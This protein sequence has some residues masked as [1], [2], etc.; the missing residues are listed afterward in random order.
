METKYLLN[1]IKLNFVLH[2]YGLI[3]VRR[4]Y[5]THLSSNFL[6]MCIK[7]WGICTSKYSTSVTDFFMILLFLL[8]A[9]ILIQRS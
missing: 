1:I 6:N 8:F 2:L 3:N 4:P 9:L 7:K 5:L